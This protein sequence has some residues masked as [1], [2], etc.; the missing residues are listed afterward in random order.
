MKKSTPFPRA[1][2]KCIVRKKPVI[3]FTPG[4]LLHY[5]SLYITTSI[6]LHDGS[7]FQ[8][9]YP[10]PDSSCAQK[11][12]WSCSIASSDPKSLNFVKYVETP[13]IFWEANK[14]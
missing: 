9:L 8:S 5:N 13:Y 10:S 11:A 3:T 12:S 1:P 14:E 2:S 4:K 6:S 7:T